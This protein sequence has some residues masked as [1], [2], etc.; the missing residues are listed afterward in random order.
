MAAVSWRVLLRLSWRAGTRQLHQHLFVEL[1]KVDLGHSFLIRNL[2]IGHDLA[3]G[4]EGLLEG[5]EIRQVQLVLIIVLGFDFFL[6]FLDLF[7][8][9]ILLHDHL[10]EI[11]LKK[12][13]LMGLRLQNSVRH[14]FPD[15]VLHAPSFQLI[16]VQEAVVESDFREQV[17]DI[18][19]QLVGVFHQT[20]PSLSSK[21]MLFY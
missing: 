11:V 5:G 15:G 3:L 2:L 13:A 8:N 4:L 7:F 19:Y 6:F 17:R 1:F 12:G 10:A 14:D 9:G 20:I 16:V 18:L 21:L